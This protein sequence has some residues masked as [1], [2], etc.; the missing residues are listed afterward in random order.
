MKGAW[1][2][3]PKSCRWY[4]GNMKRSKSMAE[5]S[6]CLEKEEKMCLGNR[7]NGLSMEMTLI[8]TKW[9]EL[10]PAEKMAIIKGGRHSAGSNNRTH[11]TKSLYSN[12]PKHQTPPN[13]IHNLNHKLIF[14][15]THP[16]GFSLPQ[17]CLSRFTAIFILVLFFVLRCKSCLSKKNCSLD[18]YGLCILVLGCHLQKATI[19]TRPTSTTWWEFG[20][21][22]PIYSFTK[23]DTYI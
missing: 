6:F 3:K 17:T 22:P 7:R 19:A 18:C 8:L 1:K 14:K 12:L 2:S 5:R 23:K 13:T 21:T 11:N 4:G 15:F 10:P 20:P 9:Q 16:P